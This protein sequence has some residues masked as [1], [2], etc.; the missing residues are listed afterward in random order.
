MRLEGP[1]NNNWSKKQ[2]VNL[3]YNVTSEFG[4]GL[5]TFLT[6]IW[7]NQTGEWLPQTG[8]IYVD[9][10]TQ[11]SKNFVFPEKLGILW[12]VEA[13][14][15]NDNNVFNFSVNNT[16]NIDTIDPVVTITTADN[17]IMSG[18]VFEVAY[19]VSEANID[20]IRVFTD[21]NI[22]GIFIVNYTNASAVSGD[23]RYIFSSAAI[24]GRYNISIVVNDSSGRETIT[25]NL[26]MIV[27]LTPPNS[28]MDN[29]RNISTVD[30]L[31]RSRTINWDTNES[32][33]YTFYIDTDVEVTDGEIF[34]NSTRSFNHSLNFDFGFNIE[35]THYINI[36]SCDAAGNCNNSEQVTFD[37]PAS[38]CNGW[39][40]YA[41]YDSI[42]NLSV[43]QNQTGAD[44]V[45][46][47]NATNQN[48]VAFTA[49]LSTNENVQMGRGTAYHVAHLFENTNDTWFRNNTNTGFYEYNL[50]VGS[51]WISI[52]SDYT[53]GNLTISFMN[54]SDTENFFPSQV[55]DTVAEF[56]VFNISFFAG[57]NNSKQD[58]VNH[59]FNFTWANATILEPCTNRNFPT[60]CMEVAWVGSGFDITWNGTSISRN[61]T[62]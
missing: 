38:V 4:T 37:T 6:R 59:L 32:T 28:G 20:H 51:N 55:N 23:F 50:T 47:W 56:F 41:V 10:N 40:Q 13:I 35:V 43:L 27:D 3:S 19:T 48:W 9:N 15:T 53:F 33:N 36:T 22:S 57:F 1:S 62:A 30:P 2:V 61:W 39:N 16:I 25:E 11:V 21:V 31:C 14:Q 58:Y 24:D 46:F 29:I 17:S 5:T 34:S 52:P 45:Y 26:T 7:T 49:G 54:Q 60:T 8:A 18:S 42:I 12:G 44:L